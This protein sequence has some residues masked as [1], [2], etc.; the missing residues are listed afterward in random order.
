MN[1]FE[2]QLRLALRREP[3]PDGFEERLALRMRRRPRGYLA[4]AGILLALAAGGW[5]QHQRR[6]EG[7][8]ARAQLLLAL[9]ISS[10]RLNASFQKISLPQE[11]P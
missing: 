4:A 11:R 6:L 2:A 9:E 5:F 3:P 7:E 1:P 8:R 10:E